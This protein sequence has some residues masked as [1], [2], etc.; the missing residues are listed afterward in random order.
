MISCSTFITFLSQQST[1]PRY[2]SM[3]IFQLI[4][5]PLPLCLTSLLL[6]LLN[7]THQDVY[8]SALSTFTKRA[9][10]IGKPVFLELFRICPLVPR[11]HRQAA[12]LP[13]P[14]SVVFRVLSLLPITEMLLYLWLLIEWFYTGDSII[15]CH[16]STGD[17]HITSSNLASL[18]AFSLCPLGL[19]CGGPETPQP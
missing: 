10:Q 17:S 16:P 4:F 7:C 19:P 13:L 18:L 11:T 14:F 3:S 6:L 1:V 12:E 9:L 8:P 5:P 2:Y 15:Q